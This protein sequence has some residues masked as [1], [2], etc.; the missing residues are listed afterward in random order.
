MTFSLHFVFYLI[1]YISALVANKRV[2]SM[3]SRVYVTDG[4]LSVC[5]SVCP[6]DRQQQRRPAGLLLISID[7]CGRRA[8]CAGAQ[9]QMRV[10]SCWEPTEEVHRRLVFYAV[11]IWQSFLYKHVQITL[12]TVHCVGNESVPIQLTQCLFP[13][14]PLRM[15]K[16]KYI[17]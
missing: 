12:R 10:A 7:S 15:L 3:P 14:P 17:F 5:P 4:R 6:I 1:L 8:A 9:Q 16:Y 13:R 2:H 11:A